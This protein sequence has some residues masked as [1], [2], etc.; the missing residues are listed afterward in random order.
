MRGITG[1]GWR[2]LA[3]RRRDGWGLGDLFPA[4]KSTALESNTKKEVNGLLMSTAGLNGLD[5]KAF[6]LEPTVARA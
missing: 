2:R 4:F 5:L 3:T 1:A 6:A